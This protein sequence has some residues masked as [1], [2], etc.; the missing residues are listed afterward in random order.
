MLDPQKE[1]DVTRMFD[2]VYKQCLES[3]REQIEDGK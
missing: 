2:E 1:A 3:L